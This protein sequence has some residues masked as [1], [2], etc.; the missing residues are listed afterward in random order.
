MPILTGQ[1]ITTVIEFHFTFRDLRNAFPDVFLLRRLICRSLYNLLLR[2]K[3]YVHPTKKINHCWNMTAYWLSEYIQCRGLVLWSCQWLFGLVL[4]QDVHE[5]DEELLQDKMKH[6][7]P[8]KVK[9]AYS[10]KCMFFADCRSQWLGPGYSA[11]LAIPQKVLHHFSADDSLM[12]P[13]NSP[14]YHSQ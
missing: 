8:Q 6:F 2:S 4:I 7:F 14:S 1:K 13:F 11:A 3:V 10:H 9:A 5:S 12:E